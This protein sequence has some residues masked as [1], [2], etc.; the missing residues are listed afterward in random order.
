[1][2][3]IQVC[4]T[5][6]PMIPLK[7]QEEQVWIHLFTSFFSLTSDNCACC[8]GQQEW[9]CLLGFFSCPTA[10]LLGTDIKKYATDFP[11]GALAKN[12]PAN[13]RHTC[14][15]P[16]PGTSHGAT[17]PVHHNYWACALEPVCHNYWARVP[18]LLKPTRL[19]PMLCDKR[20]HHNKKPVHRNEE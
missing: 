12:P 13:A 2:T 7:L 6:E 10:L 9:K 14:S 18:Q 11:G 15:S 1:M 5:T 16:G 3:W 8:H 4:K 20:S 19:D 17:K